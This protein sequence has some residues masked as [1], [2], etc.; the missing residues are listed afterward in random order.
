LNVRKK[1]K[2]ARAKN[3]TNI[4]KSNMEIR[5][6]DLEYF[7]ILSPCVCACVR[8]IDMLRLLLSL[9]DVFSGLQTPAQKTLKLYRRATNAG[10]SNVSSIRTI[11][12]KMETE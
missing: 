5:E 12:C 7:M 1:G 3:I 11:T 10:K 4:W 9:S 8:L 6:P 2:T